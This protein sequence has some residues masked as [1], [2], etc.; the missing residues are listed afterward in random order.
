M[1]KLFIS[2]IRRNPVAKFIA[3]LSIFTAFF[4]GFIAG[5]QLLKNYNISGATLTGYGCGGFGQVGSEFGTNCGIT[6]DITNT[7]SISTSTDCTSATNITIGNTYTC[8]FPLTGSITDTYTLPTNGVVATTSTASGQS[9]ACTIINNSSSTAAL[10]CS[11]IPTLGGTAGLQ[12]INVLVD[13]SITP[14]DKGDITLVTG[15][16][17][18]ISSNVSNST[19]CVSTTNLTIGNT[20]TCTFPITGGVNYMV[21]AGGIVA[22]TEQGANT[23]GN[24]SACTIL[25]TT[26]TCTNI[27][28]SPTTS[29]GLAN[30]TLQ[31][32]ATG[33]YD[34]KGD[35]TLVAPLTTITAS[36]ISNSSDCTTLSNVVLG[37]S[38][39]CSFSLTGGI[40]YVLP[41]NGI[42]AG[43][44]TASGTSIPC[45]ILGAVLTCSSIPTAGATLGG[46]NVNLFID[47]ST[48]P[49]D[50]GDV[51]IVSTTISA[52]NVSSSSTCT[53]ATNILIG[54][55]YTCT[56]PLIGGTSYALPTNGIIART[57]QGI[58]NS[59]ISPNCTIVS[60]TTLTC[61]NI[62]SSPNI[63]AGIADVTLQFDGTGGFV[64]K[65]DITAVSP[66]VVTLSNISNSGNCNSTFAVSVGNTYSCSFP[67]AGSPL[68]SYAM[69]T[70]GIRARTQISSILGNTTSSCVIINNITVQAALECILI[71]TLTG[72]TPLPTGLADVELDVNNTNSFAK[73]GEVLLVASSITALNVTNSSNC[74]STQ[75]III[76]FS[77]SCSFPLVGSSGNT[78]ALPQNGITARTHQVVNNSTNSPACSITGNTTAQALLVCN[79]IPADT[80]AGGTGTLTNGVADVE[81]LF[82]ATVPYVKKGEVTLVNSIDSDGDG[83]SDTIECGPLGNPNTHIGCPDTDND[84]TQDYL[85]QDSDGDGVKDSFEKGLSCASISSCVPRDTDGDG[86]PNY[87]DSNDDNDNLIT[88]S[89]QPDPNGDGDDADGI[90]S[91]EDGFMDYLDNDDI[92]SFR[93]S[94][95]ANMKSKFGFNCTPD[96]TFVNTSINCTGKL[97]SSRRAPSTTLK[98]RVKNQASV[99]CIFDS[100]TNAASTYA[101]NNLPVGSNGG[102]YT[103]EATLN[104]LISS[105]STQST[106]TMV[107]PFITPIIVGAQS[108]GFTETGE[109]VIVIPQIPLPRTGGQWVGTVG[110]IV[111]SIMGLGYISVAM[112]KR[113]LDL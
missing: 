106:A 10:E 47:G 19:D 17:T 25:S 95:L 67:L 57:D 64:D 78:Y 40:T 43:V 18:V 55:T 112:L 2:F 102:I 82:N 68:Q 28:S 85:D 35:V 92:S 44:Q 14:I 86:T 33:G 107:I 11:T 62:P 73:R 69:P 108:A 93:D 21:P 63:T 6:L 91:D 34:D 16:T 37:N 109:T 60:G 113:K 110:I 99:V 80:L 51:T 23:T 5:Q 84:G 31:F 27:Q 39:P 104:N 45:T 98:V 83:I 71:P 97:T 8:T 58:N 12:N 15:T 105:E 74:I 1:S 70:N 87:R 48:T 20:Y 88:S 59:A 90:D 61:T 77:Y 36:N 38:I 53:S 96:S 103:I 49:V 46:Q 24:S 89:E 9:A 52:S 7:L 50:K 111:I 4:L 94:D 32:N 26:L 29:P 76:G 41:T 3:V 66:L 65:G 101:C 72:V 42:V 81:L 54:T 13:G 30:V 22:R 75:S 100:P 56:F 79:G